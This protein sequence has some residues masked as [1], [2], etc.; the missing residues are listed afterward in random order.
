MEKLATIKYPNK[1]IKRLM[2]NEDIVD[3]FKFQSTTQMARR[4]RR[5]GRNEDCPCGSGLKFKKCCLGNRKD[6]IF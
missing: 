4:P 1:I 6:S 3:P 2:K 5:V